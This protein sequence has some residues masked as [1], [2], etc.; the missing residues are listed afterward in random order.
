LRTGP[1]LL[2][3]PWISRLLQNDG[4]FTPFEGMILSDRVFEHRDHVTIAGNR[5]WEE[6]SVVGATHKPVVAVVAFNRETDRSWN[7]ADA[8]AFLGKGLGSVILVVSAFDGKPPV[9]RFPL[10]A[11]AAA[12]AIESNCFGTAY[13]SCLGLHPRVLVV[14]PGEWPSGSRGALLF[15]DRYMLGGSTVALAAPGKLVP[16]LSPCIEDPDKPPTRWTLHGVDG[17][18]F[19]APIVGQVL[20]RI[21]EQ[22]ALDTQPIAAIWRVLATADSIKPLDPA[23]PDREIAVGTLNIQRAFDGLSAGGRREVRARIEPCAKPPLNGGNTSDG[24]GLP[25]CLAIVQPFPWADD[26]ETQAATKGKYL[27]DPA[28]PFTRGFLTFARRAD[29]GGWQRPQPLAFAQV[30]SLFR[31]RNPASDENN[32]PLFDIRYLTDPGAADGSFGVT[33]ERGARIGFRPAD[34]GIEGYCDASGNVSS[35]G[36]GDSRPAC[37]YAWDP[38]VK[39]GDSSGFLPLDLTKVESIVLPPLH[40]DAGFVNDTTPIETT[41]ISAANNPWQK[42]FVS[43]QPRLKIRKCLAL[44]AQC[45]R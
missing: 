15:P 24:A 28:W 19:A 16:V 43:T 44:P 20:A 30:L 7:V 13:P 4:N 36:K 6:S 26:V 38:T 2:L 42:P 9:P 45:A 37:L 32:I 8:S 31:A 12:K 11:S 14:A 10:G 25:P 17:S 35:G 21:I 41:R 18:S 1:S 27:T 33:V 22:A 29:G 3:Q 39:E 34:V 5:H 23:H 40:L